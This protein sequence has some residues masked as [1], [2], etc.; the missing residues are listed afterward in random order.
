MCLGAQLI[1]AALGARVYAGPVIELGFAPV[2][3]L[4]VP[5]DPLLTPLCGVP[6]LHWHGDTFDLPAGCE[7][8]ASTRTYANQAFRRGRN[9]LAVQFHPEVGE[10]PAFAGWVAES[11]DYLERAG[12]SEAA[13][14]ADHARLG[15][16]AATAGATVLGDWL[17]RIT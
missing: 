15:P 14:L 10:D 13:L 1:A 11:A 3:V 9:V 8:L 16:A 4:S 7:P 6:V 2:D 5:S 17:D 12:V